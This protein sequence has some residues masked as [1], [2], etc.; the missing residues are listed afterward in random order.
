MYGRLQKGVTQKGSFA[1]LIREEEEEKTCG[2]TNDVLER[3]KWA[4]RD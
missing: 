3:V 2:K 1:I 4:L